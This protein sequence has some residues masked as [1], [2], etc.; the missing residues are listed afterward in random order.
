MMSALAPASEP[1]ETLFA[2]IVSF[3]VSATDFA[4]FSAM[5]L[6]NARQ[7][8][9]NEDGCLRFDVLTGSQSPLRVVL[10]EVYRSEADFEA[11]LQT[12]HFLDF[13]AASRAM[14]TEKAV[15]RFRC[16]AT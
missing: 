11:H 14:V 16:E 6:A 12:P 3:V 5:I 9:S 7:T 15:E 1:G 8:I 4:A 2:V 10:Y 13:D